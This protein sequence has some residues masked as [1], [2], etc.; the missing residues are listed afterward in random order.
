MTFKDAGMRM[1]AT[2]AQ[3]DLEIKREFFTRILTDTPLDTGQARGGW[4][5]S[6]GVPDTSN[7]YVLDPDC[8]IGKATIQGMGPE[9]VGNVSWYTNA[10]DYIIE[11][12]YG[13]SG[14]APEG[15]VRV[16]IAAF[17]QIVRE[18]SGRL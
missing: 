4:H 7:A 1:I 8:A 14:Q 3:A 12:E 10:Q 16:N 17:G 13:K 5:I 6:L 11:L 9:H 18:V 15:M 2:L